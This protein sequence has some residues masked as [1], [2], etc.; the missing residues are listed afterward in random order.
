MT[1]NEEELEQPSKPVVP[2]ASSREL[3]LEY[4]DLADPRDSERPRQVYAHCPKCAEKSYMSFV[5]TLD[6]WELLVDLICQ[7]TNIASRRL[8]EM[9]KRPTD[10]VFRARCLLVHALS[11]VTG[12]DDCVRWLGF[13]GFER[14]WV[15]DV[16]DTQLDAEYATLL[17]GMDLSLQVSLRGEA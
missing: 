12:E 7:V 6:A 13:A 2:M 8:L 17:S 1:K 9:G 16:L 5:A 11:K 10:D 15:K 14:R 3:D 4:G